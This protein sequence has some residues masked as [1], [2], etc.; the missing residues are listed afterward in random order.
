MANLD[1]VSLTKLQ[2]RTV[3]VLAL[4]Q[5]FGGFGLGSTLSIG[6]LLAAELS[7]TPAWS[8]AAATF[9]TLGTATWAIP[10]ANLAYRRGR[11]VALGLGAALAISGAALMIVA[12]F[13]KF[14]P[15]ELVAL[16]LLGAGSAASLQAR[17]AANDIPTGTAKAKD[18][19]FVV[20]ATTIGAVVGPNLFGPG[21]FVGGLIGLP[22]LTGPF[23]FTILAQ[24]TATLIFWFGLRPDPLLVAKEVAGLPPKRTNSSIGDALRV[25]REFPVAG[26][27]VL[28]IALSHMVMVSVMSMTPVHLNTHG[29]DISAVG[30]TISLHIAGMYA[31]SPVFGAL[32]DK[33]GPRKVILGGQL[34]F[35][36]ALASAGLWQHDFNLVVFGLFLLGLGWSAS[37]VSGAALLTQSLPQEQKTKVQGL[38]DSLMNLS[39]AFGGAISGSILALY[40]F[41]GLNAAA[42]IPVVLIVIATALSRR[43]K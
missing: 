31:F 19:A 36:G 32:A 13:L 18:L 30:F 28:S 2:K 6:A 40:T 23:L 41:G 12:A 25:I 5:M 14:F 35:L 27:A 1:Q 16:F 39:G 10:L 8:G 26:F 22:H 7:G 17:F 42:L 43:W 29:H 4:G 3:R 20:W 34:I 33:I 21:E 9:S 15:L 38:S 37:T 24:L 11:R